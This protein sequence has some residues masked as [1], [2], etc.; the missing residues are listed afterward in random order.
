MGKWNVI[1]IN[2]KEHELVWE[3]DQYRLDIVGAFSATCSGSDTVEL[4]EGWKLLYSGVD[5][6]MSAQAGVV[7]LVSLCWIHCVT[8]WMNR[9]KVC[10]LKLGLQE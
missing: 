3:A 2:V 1:P 4:N 8:D 6:T 7:I 5:V 9:R 10:I